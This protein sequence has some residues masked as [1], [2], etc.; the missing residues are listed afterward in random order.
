MQQSM[1]NFLGESP[2]A[3]N[4]EGEWG[5]LF[6]FPVLK[7]FLQMIT[8]VCCLRTS[9]SQSCQIHLQRNPLPLLSVTFIRGLRAQCQA[10]HLLPNARNQKSLVV[11][12]KGT[13]HGWFPH[14]V[15]K[16]MFMRIDFR[17]DLS[18]SEKL[19]LAE[20]ISVEISQRLGLREQ[21][22]VISI[23]NPS[24]SVRPNDTHFSIGKS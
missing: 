19:V 9:L 12:L 14:K 24:A 13:S 1:I 2:L 10:H 15:E 22:E 4:Q 16:L 6:A 3:A 8:R 23:I 11:K 21:I 7:N 18:E 17:D 5:H 20:E